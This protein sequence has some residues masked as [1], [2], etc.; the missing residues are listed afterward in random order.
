MV[1]RIA[2]LI[3]YLGQVYPAQDENWESNTDELWCTTVLIFVD[4]TR[5][6][7]TT[8]DAKLHLTF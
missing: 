2:H 7:I 1:V 4:D 8:I 3:L 6:A 5:F